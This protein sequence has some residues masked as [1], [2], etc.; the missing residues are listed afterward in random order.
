ME[1]SR[2]RFSVVTVNYNNARVLIEVVAQTLEVLRDYG[3]EIIIVDNGS[4]DNSHAVLASHFARHPIVRVVTS[5]RNGGFGYGCNF[6]AAQAKSSLIWF[7]NSDAWVTRSIGLEDALKLAMQ[8]TTGMVGTTVVFHD[9]EPSP[10][11]G[12]D[13]SF[14]YFLFGSVR[15]GLLYRKLPTPIQAFVRAAL[16]P[17]QGVFGGYVRALDHSKITQVY[18]SRGVGG[19]S[20]LISRASFE[21]LRGFDEGFFLYDEDGDLCLRSIEGGLINFVQPSIEVR[22]YRSATTSKVPRQELKKI[23]RTSRLRLIRK[24]FS[25]ARRIVLIVATMLTWR[26]L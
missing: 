10:Q 11:G 13:M 26:L 9:G 20:F 23:K 4:T 1:A 18:E 2:P 12:S 5:G 17:C 7:L 6:G 25:G 15:L 3:P 22:T 24:H 21:K 16:R 14:L 19:A 8:P